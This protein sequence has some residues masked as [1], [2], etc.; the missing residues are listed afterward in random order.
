MLKSISLIL[1]LST[2]L[3]WSLG[4]KVLSYLQNLMFLNKIR[5]II[6]V[7]DKTSSNAFSIAQQFTAAISNQTFKCP[8]VAPS[9][10]DSTQKYRSFDGICNNLQQ[11]LLG[12]IETPHKR[13]LSPEY[14]DGVGMPKVKSVSGKMLPNPRLLSNTLSMDPMNMQELIWSNLWVI[15]GQFLTHDITATALSSR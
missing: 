13:L 3:T 12:S 2:N 15:F 10:C 4:K 8:F 5:K 1:L 9:S 6:L 14:D 11:P 7:D